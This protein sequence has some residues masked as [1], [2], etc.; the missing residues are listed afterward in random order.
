VL[1]GEPVEV[2]DLLGTAAQQGW[3]QERLQAAIAD[4]VGQVRRAWC[5]AL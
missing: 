1:V 2:S 5:T 3:A 4:R